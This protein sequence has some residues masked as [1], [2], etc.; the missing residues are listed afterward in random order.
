MERL[1]LVIDGEKASHDQLKVCRAEK[2][3]ILGV[4]DCR[5]HDANAELCRELPTLPAF[6]NID[7]KKCLSGFVSAAE[8]SELPSRL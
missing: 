7:T 6:C 1:V 8:L 5:R 4:E 2:P 3:P